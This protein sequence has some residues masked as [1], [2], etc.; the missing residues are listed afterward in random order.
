[1]DSVGD[2]LP[3]VEYGK[4]VAFLRAEVT[5]DLQ[6]DDVIIRL[7]KKVSRDMKHGYN[8]LD[9]FEKMDKDKNGELD[10]DE[11]QDALRNIGISIDR[12][13]ARRIIHKFGVKGNSVRYK[14]FIA[15]MNP[16]AA[17]DATLTAPMVVDKLKRVL[18]QRFGSSANVSREL[19]NAFADFDTN[20]NG[21]IS[22]I[23]FQ[24]AMDSV[25]VD[26]TRQELHLIFKHYA[27]D[28]N[29]LDYDDFLRLVD[30]A[31]GNA[32]GSRERER[33]W[34]SDDRRDA[35]D[36]SRDRSRERE[37]DRDKRAV[38]EIVDRVRRQLEDYLGS[39][40]GTD[41]ITRRIKEAFA[42]M[43]RNGN[44][45]VDKAEFGDAMEVLKV[46]M[47]RDEINELFLFYDTDRNGL[48]YG[49]F[50]RMLGL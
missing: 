20:R 7:Q 29:D 34:R 1:V 35:R 31:P 36:R 21:K 6:T 33:E 43:D 15:A 37:R 32:G 3:S 39:S 19:K 41:R 50:I 2:G 47:T 16:D 9:E 28:G 11:L 25:K 18:E 13:E 45:L 42:D 44:G 48:D 23:E 38:Q 5:S 22:K 8:L 40:A 24:D 4:L 10:V 12:E 26:V 46:R 14:D 27:N 30:A 17:F 49:E